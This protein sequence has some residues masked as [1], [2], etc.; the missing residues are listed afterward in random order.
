MDT[1]ALLVEVGEEGR[2]AFCLASGRWIE[3]VPYEN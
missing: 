1:I 2:A 3:L